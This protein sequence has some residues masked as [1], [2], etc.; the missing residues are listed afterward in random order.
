MAISRRTPI[1]R[2]RH[3]LPLWVNAVTPILQV[4]DL[5]QDPDDE[6]LIVAM[7]NFTLQGAIQLFGMIAN[8]APA[9]LRTRLLRATFDLLG[10]DDVPVA[11]GT[12][13][14]KDPALYMDPQRWNIPYLANV[15]IHAQFP[16]GKEL[17]VTQLSNVPDHSVTLLCVSG[18]TD[19]AMLLEEESALT[20]RAIRKVVI[21]GGVIRKDDT[22]VL[23]HG[24]MMPDDAANNTF[25]MNAAEYVYRELQVRGIP[26]TVLTKEAAYAVPFSRSFYDE[27]AK[28]GH[29]IGKR[30]CDMQKNSIEHLWYRSNLPAQDAKRKALPAS[31]D[32]QWFCKQFLNG[33]GMDRSGNDSIWDIVNAFYL[34]DPMA[35]IAA[36]ERY[37]PIYYMP[38]EFEIRG[39]VHNIIGM[40]REH[41]NVKYPEALRGFIHAQIVSALDIYQQAM[42]LAA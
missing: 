5:Q 23:D 29:P 3:K 2:L 38:N 41:H 37:A 36:I 4:T 1:L 14:N 39:A 34:Y 7:G 8:L 6:D 33:E 10:M 40:T 17:F 25:D 18:L 30:L 12:D 31:R 35:G 15:P 16:K 32:K 20:Q 19:T 21:M 9:E 13:C 22:V 27:L 42:L 24:L 11:Q 28:T 26:M